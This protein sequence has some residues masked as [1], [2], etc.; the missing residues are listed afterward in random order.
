MR[1]DKRRDSQ[2]LEEGPLS[3]E[4]W[5]DYARLY[6]QVMMQ[7]PGYRDL[8]DLVMAHLRLTDG[9]RVADLGC[10]VGNFLHAIQERGAAVELHGVDASAQML[11]FARELLGDS[12]SIHLHQMDLEDDQ[13]VPVLSDA[14]ITAAFSVNAVYA[15][16][17]PHIF[18]DRWRGIMR[19][20]GRIVVCNPHTASYASV[21]AR[22]QA[23]VH[24]L[25][26]ELPAFLRF[27]D[28]IVKSAQRQDYWFA[29]LD[30]V[31]N[32]ISSRGFQVLDVVDDAYDNTNV[33]VVAQAT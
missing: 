27:N 22:L 15:L 17:D 21:F 13:W 5:D 19:K 18:F 8:I 23:E 10:G 9:D 20:G 3:P 12:S 32:V 1:S 31:A 6:R 28:R 11:G 7:V 4:E 33:V 2:V 26:P 30:E 25:P 14:G 24:P 16:S 29:S